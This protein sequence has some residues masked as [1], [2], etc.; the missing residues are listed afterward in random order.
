MPL[1]LLLALV[2][3]LG[4]CLFPPVEPGGDDGDPRREDGGA[5]DPDPEPPVDPGDWVRREDGWE[6][7]GQMERA[8]SAGGVPVGQEVHEFRLPPRVQEL[9][10]RLEWEAAMEEDLDVRFELRDGGR[11]LWN[12][13]VT[14]GQT[15]DPDRPIVAKFVEI[16]EIDA[17]NETLLMAT[18]TAKV[19]YDTPFTVSVH[20]WYLEPSE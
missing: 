3:L 7:V 11:S 5:G 19:A 9:T 1:A 13:S 14:D 8:A 15:G 2:I 17:E 4:G 12:H 16:P 18:V 20:V 6:E 10:L